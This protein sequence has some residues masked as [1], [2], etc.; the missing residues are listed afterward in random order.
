MARVVLDLVRTVVWPATILIA[1]LLLRQPIGAVVA[2]AT[3]IT[4]KGPGFE[5]QI[6]AAT[7]ILERNVERSA[8][9]LAGTT[10]G[11][12]PGEATRAANDG[13]DRRV[14]RGPDGAA[15]APD[16]A[17]RYEAIEQLVAESAAWGWQ[18]ARLG[19]TEPPQPR[20]L[21][22]RTGPAVLPPPAAE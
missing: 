15:A 18:M 2:R 11:S 14:A 16:D 7:R 6:Q 10:P 22:D 12:E 17:A 8:R 4:V 19:S 20:I 3:R 5:G 21:W 1:I 9:V 13:E